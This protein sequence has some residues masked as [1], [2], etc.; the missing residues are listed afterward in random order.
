[1]KKAN[2]LALIFFLA[3]KV[4]ITISALLFGLMLLLDEEYPLLA[5]ICIFMYFIYP[6]FSFLTNTTSLIFQLSNITKNKNKKY[7]VLLIFTILSILFSVFFG[8]LI[9]EV[10]KSV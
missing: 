8:W 9:L 1:M 4:Y 10:G 5:L 6:I 2:L 3:S 7:V